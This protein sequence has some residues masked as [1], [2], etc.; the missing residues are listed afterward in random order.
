MC[1]ATLGDYCSGRYTGELADEMQALR[2]MLDGLSYIHA[3]KFVHRDI[4]PNNILIDRIGHLKI[5]DFGFSK[6]ISGIN[7]FSISDAGKGTD[8]WMA[9]ELLKIIIETEENS[10]NTTLTHHA[11][12]AVDVF[13]LGCVFFFF[14]TKGKHPFGSRALRSGNIIMDKYDLSG[15][16]QSH[17]TIVK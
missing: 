12:T 10:T 3:Q 4:K 13:P 17:V 9:P 5:A 2:Q 8:G 16:S 15:K 7:S 6:P 14:L 11:T 1:V